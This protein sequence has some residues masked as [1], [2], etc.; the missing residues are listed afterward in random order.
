MLFIN[1]LYNQPHKKIK[2]KKASALIKKILIK[3]II[4]LPQKRKIIILDHQI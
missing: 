3:F 2:T 4:Y 1:T